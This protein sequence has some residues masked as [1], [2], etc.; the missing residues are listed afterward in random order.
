MYLSRFTERVNL[1]MRGDDIYSSMSDYLADRVVANRRVQLRTHCELRA[2]SG[3][4]F[5][6]KVTLEDNRTRQ[7]I[8]EPSGGVFVFIGA[9][10]VTDFLGADV[11]RNSAGFVLTGSDVPKEAW[12]RPDRSPF[13]LESSVPGILVAGDCRQGSTKRVAF[14]VGDG[15]LAVTCLHE[16]FGT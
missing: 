15:A 10:P 6:E 14:A 1:V 7:Q 8:E 16:L 4:Q 5:L 9:I 3:A 12:K 13:S 11:A 2:V